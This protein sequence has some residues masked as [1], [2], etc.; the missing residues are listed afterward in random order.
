[1]LKVWSTFDDSMKLTKAQI[2]QIL[3]CPHDE[4][5]SHSDR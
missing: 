2:L 4:T 1:M 5:Y 3:N